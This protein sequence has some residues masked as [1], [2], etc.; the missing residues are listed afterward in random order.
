MHN[1]SLNATP[2]LCV[3]RFGL[4]CETVMADH[5]WARVNSMLGCAEILHTNCKEPAGKDELSE[6]TR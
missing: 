2:K 5:N 6:L 3:V 4:S 1:K